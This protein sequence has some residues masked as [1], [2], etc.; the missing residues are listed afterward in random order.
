M[1]IDVFYLIFAYGMLRKLE[2]A[3][4]IFEVFRFSL[5]MTDN[6]YGNLFIYSFLF[7]NLYFS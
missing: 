1:G 3:V 7:S 2:G 6:N 4:G 5:N